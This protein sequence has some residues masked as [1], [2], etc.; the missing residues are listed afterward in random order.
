MN[1]GGGEASRSRDVTATQRKHVQQQQRR[2]LDPLSSA[3]SAHTEPLNWRYFRPPNNKH[4]NSAFMGSVY[5]WVQLGPCEVLHEP[6]FAMIHADSRE[7]MGRMQ[8]PP[9]RC[10]S[11]LILLL[12]I[13]Q[14]YTCVRVTR[15]KEGAAAADKP[16]A[17]SRCLSGCFL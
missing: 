8:T 16:L 6:H 17:Q 9:D 3:P 12:F 10:S 7:P 15:G 5:S 2:P 11:L 4:T 14:V 1:G 13:I